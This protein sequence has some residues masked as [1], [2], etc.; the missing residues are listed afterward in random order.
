MVKLE[1]PVIDL[2]ADDHDGEPAAQRRRVQVEP[3]HLLCPITREMFRDPVMVMESGHTYERKAIE[4][5]LQ[6][7]RTDPLTRA[8]I[9]TAPVTNMNTRNAVQAWLD[10]NPGITPDGWSSREMLPPQRVATNLSSLSPPAEADLPERIRV[11]VQMRREIRRLEMIRELR[12]SEADS[13]EMI[14]PLREPRHTRT[15]RPD[16]RTQRPTMSPT[17]N[18]TISSSTPRRR[19]RS[20]A[21][22]RSPDPSM[23]C[24]RPDLEV[25]REW[26]ESCPE[27]RDLWR[28]DDASHWQGVTWSDRRVTRLRLTI[29]RL[30]GELPR[31]EGLTSLQAVDL[32]NNQLSGPIP[33]RL[34]EGLTSLQLVWLNNNKLS[35]P[36]PEKLFEGLTSLENVH[37]NNNQLS[38]P[39]PAKLF[40]G[41]TSLQTLHISCNQLS[42][43]IPEKLFEG[44][45]SLQTVNLY[46]NQLSGPIPEKLF[47][48]LTSLQEVYLGNNQLSGPIPEKLFEGLTSLQTV[49]LHYNQLSGP[50]PEKL[51]EGLTSLWTVNLNCN[52]LSGPIP[53][54]LFEGLTSLQYVDFGN[55]QL[56]GPIPEKLFEG[57]TSLQT[58]GLRGNQLVGPIP[59]TLF[60]GLTSL[61]HVY[62][63]SNQLM[64]SIPER[65]RA[66]VML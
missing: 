65:L 16:R 32:S 27:L 45:T 49:D 24:H 12:R 61:K 8:R 63:L 14:M 62:T 13:S 11:L 66:V 7:D 41:L 4:R 47:E 55:N 60:E 20:A 37:L 28:G 59:E 56:S 10:E 52:Q 5:H 51:F 23:E 2:T 17:S 3:D 1:Y 50:I 29:K 26:R 46:D 48:G 15:V 53:A 36:I 43:P 35:G 40:E 30:S 33:D 22:T 21:P 18:F 57:L 31:L 6:N 42:G 25:L 58:V 54:K 44:L 38:G 9:D 19:G 64:G 39:I 34:F